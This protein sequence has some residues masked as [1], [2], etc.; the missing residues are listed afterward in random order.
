MG[1]VAILVSILIKAVKNQINDKEKL[2]SKLSEDEK[3]KISI[4]VEEAIEWLDSNPDADIPSWTT[5]NP[6]ISLCFYYL[7]PCLLSQLFQSQWCILFN[8]H[9]TKPRLEQVF[10]KIVKFCSP[11]AYPS[12]NLHA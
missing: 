2:G 8:A 3:T 12:A 1:Q 11:S 7:F 6:L 10:A 5:L 4:A 9:H